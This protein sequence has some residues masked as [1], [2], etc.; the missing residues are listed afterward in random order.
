M[1]RYGI[2][3]VREYTPSG[4]IAYYWNPAVI[5]QTRASH[6]LTKLRNRRDRIVTPEDKRIRRLKVR[7]A[8]LERYRDRRLAPLAAKRGMTIKELRIDLGIDKA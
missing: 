1:T 7:E 8:S 4:Q 6:R 5:L 3:P 2:E